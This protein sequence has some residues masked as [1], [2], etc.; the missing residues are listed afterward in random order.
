MWR[1]C[2]RRLP[3]FGRRFRARGSQ[4]P[5]RLPTRW[6]ATAFSNA[7]T[8]PTRCS[9][10]AASNFGANAVRI[11]L[12]PLKLSARGSTS[13]S[14][15]DTAITVRSRLYAS[16]CAQIS[17]STIA[18]GLAAENVHLH[19]RFDRAEIDFSLPSP[20]IKVADLPAVDGCVQDGGD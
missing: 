12:A 6:Y 20:L 5:G 18:G 3:G 15:V 19:R 16:K 10:S 8:N 9:G 11:C 1:G 17:F 14:A 7:S 4:R 13:L 2:I